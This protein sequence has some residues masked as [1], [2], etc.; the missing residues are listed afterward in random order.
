[1]KQKLT[2][3]QM[4]VLMIFGFSGIVGVL[5]FALGNGFGNAGA[6]VGPVLIWG[7]LEQAPFNTVIAQL[8]EDD[9]RLA[10]VRYERRDPRTFYDDLSE[11][12]ASGKGPDLIVLSSK[13]LVRHADKLLPVSYES[14]P[15]RNFEESF[16]QAAN[17]FLTEQGALGVPIAM[18]PLVMYANRDLLSAAGFVQPPKYWDEL[19]TIAE[20]VTRKDDAKNVSKSAVAF[21]EYQNVQN[22]KDI[23]ATL[24]IQAGAEI[25][26]RDQAGRLVPAL[27]ARNQDVQQPAQ[28]GLRFYTEFANP[29]KTVYTWNR[30]LPNSREAFSTGDLA[31]YFGYASE[32]Q[33][34]QAQNPNLNFTVAMLPQIRGMSRNFTMGELYA[35]SIPRGS[36]NPAGAQ[37][38]AFILAGA[39]P[40][41]MISELRAMPSPH[42]DVLEALRTSTSTSPVASVFRDST[43]IAGSW[44][45]PD[46]ERTEAV[47]RGMIE[48][49]TSGE[50]R[51]QDAVAEGDKALLDILNL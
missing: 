48:G 32:Y 47:F 31:L 27:A 29:G 13:Y 45:D 39:K 14:I 42:V 12:I 1:M 38:V 30:A 36:Y 18:D 4:I 20:K 51:L 24:I 16:V 6:Q 19:F 46:P 11:A 35:F 43:L 17:V 40:S 25:V 10:Q 7:T 21:G 34:I 15:R 41:R 23:L 3:F 37:I 2:P 33:L 28:S 8:A 22:A 5:F 44:L 26:G 49:V 50:L 9:P